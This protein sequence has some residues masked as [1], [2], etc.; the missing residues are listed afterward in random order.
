MNKAILIN[1]ENPPKCLIRECQTPLIY[2]LGLNS[3]AENSNLL[4]SSRDAIRAP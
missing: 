3:L 4:H 1:I 2:A